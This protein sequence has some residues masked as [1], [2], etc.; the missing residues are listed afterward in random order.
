MV[1]CGMVSHPQEWDWLG[2]HEQVFCRSRPCLTGRKEARKT[3]LTS[4]MIH[5][6]MGT[7]YLPNS[8][9]SVITEKACSFACEIMRRSK[10]SA[11]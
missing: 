2:Y 1:R 5:H 7:P 10:G 9:S 11:W 8:E 4:S 6:T 3:A